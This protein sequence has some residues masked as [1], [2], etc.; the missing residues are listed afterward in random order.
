MRKRY[1]DQS[2][3]TP[4]GK[5]GLYK[6]CHLGRLFMLCTQKGSELPVGHCDR[7]YKGRC[8]FAGNNVT[9]QHKDWAIFQDLGSAP[10]SLSAAKAADFHGLLPGNNTELADARQAYTQAILNNDEVDTY[11]HVPLEAWPKWWHEKGYKDPVC[12][13]VLALY[14]HPD[15]STYW[16]KHCESHL[17]EQGFTPVKNWNSC[18]V[19]KKLDLFLV[20]Y[21]DDFK[22]SGPTENLARGW[23]LIQTKTS[24]TKGLA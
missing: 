20:V 2:N 7:K 15:S 11:V 22:L 24:K 6:S 17:L 16:E 19:H 12:P 18:Y 3:Q 4:V 13:L 1:A 14:G 5:S 21:V 9:D 8:V 23:K 10:A